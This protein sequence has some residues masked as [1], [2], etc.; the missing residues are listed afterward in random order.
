MFSIDTLRLILNPFCKM[1]EWVFLCIYFGAIF[2]YCALIGLQGFDM[3]DEGF[4]LTAYQQLFEHPTSAEYQFLYYNSILVGAIWNSIFGSYGILGFRFFSVLL[5][6]AM[7]II[8]YNI[9][10]PYIN[11][12]CIFAGVMLVILNLRY[13]MVFH[14]NEFTALMSLLIIWALYESLKRKSLYLIAIAGGLI[15]INSFSRLPNISLLSLSLMIIPFYLYTKDISNTLRMLGS[16]IG[17]FIVGIVLQI[18]LMIYLG[19]WDIFVDNI[20]SS[21]VGQVTDAETGHSLSNILNVY[22]WNYQEVLSCIAYI[23]VYPALLWY[24]PELN[25][26]KILQRIILVMSMIIFVLKMWQISSEYTFII[27]AL[28]YLIFAYFILKRYSDENITYLILIA[29]IV[30]FFLPFGSTA[31]IDNMGPHCIWI[32]TPLALGLAYHELR[33]TY[34]TQPYKVVLLSTTLLISMSM[35][36]L[37]CI[38]HTYKNA[39]FDYAKR[40]TMTCRIHHPL[41]NTYTTKE[42]CIIVDELLLHLNEYVKEGDYLLAWYSVP[43]VH[44]LTHTYPYL[45]CAWPTSLDLHQMRQHFINAEKNIPTLPVILRHKSGMCAWPVHNDDWDSTTSTDQWSFN[46]QTIETIQRFIAKHNYIVAWENELWQILV[47][48]NL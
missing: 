38:R 35:L 9:L 24:I 45:N 8:V 47:P 42:R 2:L 40:T 44:Y 12:W 14:W 43:M 29:T 15:A 3:C 36:S 48:N 6:V 20:L 25:N 10:K 33:D 16:A 31:G 13:V 46:S 19:H 1:K 21:G 22:I 39:Y 11:R 23:I 41:A 32:S 28:S 34:N 26:S 17:G 30:M 4:C 18:G 37:R 27:Y 5:R 7:A